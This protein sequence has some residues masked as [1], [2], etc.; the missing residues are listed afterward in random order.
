MA[1]IEC[2]NGHVFDNMQY[3]ACP[4]CN[5]GGGYRVDFGANMNN[6]IGKTVPVGA[7]Y[8]AP[9][10]QSEIGAT[11]APVSYQQ[12]QGMQQTQKSSQSD[13]GKTV[14]V[15]KKKMQIEPVVGW[16]VCIEGADKGKSYS[17]LA[18]NNSIGR[19]ENMDISISGD[20]TIS[21][22][23]HARLGYDEKH[24]AFHLIPGESSNN[25]YIGDEP[26]Y[27]PTQIEANTIIE[28]GE[29]KLMFVPFCN[30]KFTWKEGIKE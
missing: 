13:T 15:F 1:F 26:I 9:F 21:R 24:N 25:I 11:V 8:S 29:T 30:D 12:N 20:T 17:I 4:Y 14:A 5:G 27:V 7:G 28:I 19:G 3:Q 6:G 10:Q 16:F 22:E 18:K 23:N 2:G